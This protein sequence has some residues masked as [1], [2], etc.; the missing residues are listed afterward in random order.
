MIKVQ[1]ER[2][3]TQERCNL[4]KGQPGKSTTWNRLK[5][6]TLKKKKKKDT[7]IEHHRTQT[8]NRPILRNRY[9]LVT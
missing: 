9:K 8:N 1:H 5:G 6:Q 3:I 2:N 7:K 4:E